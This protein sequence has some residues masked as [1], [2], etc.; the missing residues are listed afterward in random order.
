MVK[1][2]NDWD[3]ILKEEFKKTYYL[4]LQAFLK[5]DYEAYTVFPP[6][7]DIFNGFKLTSY[8]KTKVVLLGQDPYIKQGEAHGLAFSVNKGVRIPPS[9]K[10]VYKEIIE[11]VGGVMPEHGCLESWA[12]QGVL[13]LN[14][15]LTVREGLS[16]S[17]KG[18]GWE[19]FTDQIIRI[20][21]EKA[22]PVVFMLWGNHAKS[23]ESFITNPKHLV[24][25]AAHPSPLA[26]GAFFGSK[27]FSQAN[28]FLASEKRGPI[29]WQIK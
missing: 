25:T 20:L 23:K 9:L 7:D 27:H 14:T 16:A 17:H 19:T 1:L 29:D 10:N 8:E 2:N 11:D 3:E 18:K 26:R 28:T 21:N 12:S 22:E 24:L 4:K 13:L 15:T 6:M 5:K